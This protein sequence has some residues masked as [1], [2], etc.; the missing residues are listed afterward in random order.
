MT[1]FTHFYDVFGTQTVG[2]LIQKKIL[3]KFKTL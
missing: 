1:K 2:R 3:L